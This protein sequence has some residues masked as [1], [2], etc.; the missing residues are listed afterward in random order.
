MMRRQLVLCVMLMTSQ[1]A[2]DDLYL[3]ASGAESTVSSQRY[4]VTRTFNGSGS[5]V[6]AGLSYFNGSGARWTLARLGM[7]GRI[8]DSVIMR[9]SIDVGPGRI[10]GRRISYRKAG[11]GTTWIASPEWS[12][13][14]S[15]TYINIDDSIGHVLGVSVSRVIG[16]RHS[17]TLDASR[18]AGGN[19]DTEQLGL[20]FRWQGPISYLG[21]A[22]VGE[23]RNPVLLNEVG[24][25]FGS[26]DARLRQAY[27]GIEFPIG[28]YSLLTLFD[29]LRL[30]DTIR[31]EI[32][33]VVRI[34]FGDSSVSD[35]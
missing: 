30:D 20:K 6:E 23:T 29:Y 33:F 26:S 1:A 4:S 11:F 19:L 15:D 28:D 22:Y 16:K 17:V 14:V 12:V 18:S 25:G 5:G 31:R 21:G 7:N 32:T 2:A 3:Q 9:G 13:D 24:T 35:E 8:S 27:A 10:D 34:P